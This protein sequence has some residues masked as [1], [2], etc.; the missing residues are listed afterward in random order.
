MTARP[1]SS[2]A[3]RWF[4][5]AGGVLLLVAALEY[6][7]LPRLV[8][9]RDQVSLVEDMSLVLLVVALLL[10]AASL[11]AYTWLTQEILG[12]DARL[13]FGT[14]LRIDLTGLGLSHVLP[15]GGATAA[16]LRL[17][18]MSA[19]GVA[20]DQGISLVTVQAL[21]S[22]F[23]LLALLVTGQLAS[24][25]RSGLPVLAVLVVGVALLAAGATAWG[26]RWA[27]LAPLAPE[28]DAS[29]SWLQRSQVLA[30]RAG[31][32]AA[33]SLRHA[34]LRRRGAAWSYAN[35]ALDCACLW[36]CLRAYGETV[37]PELRV[38]AY[39]LA[40]LVGMVPITP[41]GIGVIEGLL[42]PSLIATGADAGAVVLGVLT[43]RLLQ[44][45]L[46]V[47]VAALA[48]A[49]LVWG[50]RRAGPLPRQGPAR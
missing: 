32:R 1:G 15:G 26:V 50:H 2:R 23:G 30:L 17:R 20:A 49:S 9:A 36:V 29:E 46:P 28:L 22:F 12:E 35:W 47:P 21:L 16:G 41:G 44:Y 48:G 33:E 25:P 24:L 34:S 7:V 8:E 27:H 14:Q 39:G 18:L 5:G 19:R 13:R 11:A 6:G 37:A 43:W 4:R 42:V 31:Q 40:N 10:E 3:W 45:W 38:S